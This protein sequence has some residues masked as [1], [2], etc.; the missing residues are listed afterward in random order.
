MGMERRG[1]LVQPYGLVNQKWE[2]PVNKAKPFEISKWVGLE[3]VSKGKS[4]PGSGRSRHG[5]DCRF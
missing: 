2:E 4:K 3:G 5:V 1:C